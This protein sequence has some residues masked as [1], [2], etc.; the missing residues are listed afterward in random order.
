[1]TLSKFAYCLTTCLILSLPSFAQ[2]TSGEIVGIVYDQTG[3]VVPGAAVE[4]RNEATGGSAK[5][6]STSSG[7]YRIPNLPVGAY[8]LEVTATGF[9][10]VEVAKVQVEL[11][12]T[13]AANVTLQVGQA[14]TAVEVRGDAMTIDATNAQVGVTFQQRQ[15]ADLPITA[16]GSGVINLSLLSS[17]VSTSGA[18]GVGSG[19][20][21]GGQRPRNNNFT[22]E[23]IDNNSKSITG[24]LSTIPNDAVAEFTLLTNQFAP[25]NGHS[26]GGQF[27]QVVKSGTNQYHGMLLEYLQNRNLNAADQ[28]SVVNQVDLHPRFDDN[29]FGGNFGGP[30]RKNRLFFFGDVEREPQ[31]AATSPGQI[32]AP[33]QAGYAALASIPGLSATNL[34]VMK[35]Y[36]APAATAT[37]AAATPKGHY[38]VIG[39]QTIELGQLPVLAPNYTDNTFVVASVDYGI[40]TWDQLRGRYIMQRTS[41]IDNLAALPAFFTTV[42][43]NDYLATLSEFH[44]FTPSVT[45][46]FRLGYNRQNQTFGTGPQQFPGL[47]KFPN[48]TINELGIDIGP[49]PGAP[50]GTIQNTYQGTDNLTWTKAAHTLKFGVD[51]R[52]YIAPQQFTQRSRGDYAWSTLEGFLRDLTPDV[53]A[54][55]TTGD[56]T[57]YGDQ[58]E[59]AFHVNDDW[60]L[61][62]NLTI[63]LGLRYE[64][65]TIP[66]GERSQTLNAISTVPGLIDFREPRVQNHNFMPRVGFAWSPGSHGDM[67]IRAGFGINYDKLFDNLGILSLPPQYNRPWTSPG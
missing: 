30:I 35:Q 54:E 29:R 52:K 67:S 23:G 63:N 27:N 49:D 59:T 10:K 19:P 32:F 36:L 61:R 43:S 4:A 24:P 13:A 50:Q 11:N 22:V 48:L 40:G 6:V 33:T 47:D 56:V 51:F 28:Q 53:T 37:P 8:R 42:P 44:N 12:R 14:V 60:K 1:M 34:S 62:P 38:P 15:V 9:T 25:E 7:Q 3:A 20:S 21:V 64:R 31:G 26:S 55:R 66:F 5:T 65:V 17:G 58:T 45:N 16:T 46:E 41:Q 39:G 2:S 57:Y 18:V